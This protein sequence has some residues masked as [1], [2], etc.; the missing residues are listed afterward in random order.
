MT[1]YDKHILYFKH[2]YHELTQKQPDEKVRYIITNLME[3]LKHN[4]LIDK[5]Y[6]EHNY[7]FVSCE[8]N[9]TL[10][11]DVDAEKLLSFLTMIY[12]ID[13]IDANSDAYMIYYKNQM[14]LKI[15][16]TLITKLSVLKGE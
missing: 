10:I 11:Y 16:E 8:A 14:I 1:S 13:F 2:V 12:R 4:H 5:N 15:L 7:L 6:L 3:Y 9:Q